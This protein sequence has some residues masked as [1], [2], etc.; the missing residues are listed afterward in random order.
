LSYT[1]TIYLHVISR[2]VCKGSPTSDHNNSCGI[3]YTKENSMSKNKNKKYLKRRQKF[4]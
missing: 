2:C 4:E 1:N 3:N